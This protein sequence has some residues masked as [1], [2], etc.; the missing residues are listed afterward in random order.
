MGYLVLALSC[1]EEETKHQ[2]G[3]KSFSPECTARGRYKKGEYS[4]KSP[5][6]G[7]LAVGGPS[8]TP[9]GQRPHCCLQASASPGELCS[10]PTAASAP[11]LSVVMKLGLEPQPPDPL[12]WALSVLPEKNKGCCGNI[13][14]CKILER[15]EEW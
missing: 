3:Q 1:T 12:P 10:S 5:G 2:K 11:A 7:V 6:L 14:S 15:Q 4:R 9:W 8:C 13:P